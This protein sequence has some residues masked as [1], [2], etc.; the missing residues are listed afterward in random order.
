MLVEANCDTSSEHSLS[1]DFSSDESDIEWNEEK[2]EV[3]L[4][5]ARKIATRT[6]LLLGATTSNML[7]RGD[8]LK[9]VSNFAFM[10]M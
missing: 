7:F 6:P 1:T 9:S 2:E 10:L 4:D 3:E 5:R 8:S